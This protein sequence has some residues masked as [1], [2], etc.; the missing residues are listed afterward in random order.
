MKNFSQTDLKPEILPF[1]NLKIGLIA[2][3]TDFTI[4]QD[5]KRICNNQ[6]V[7][8]YVNRIPFNNPLNHENY[9][10]MVDHL[11]E[12][13]KNILPGEKIDSIAYGC[14][15]GTVAI[16]EKIIA[17]KIHQSKPNSYVSTPITAAIKSFSKLKIKKLAVLTPYPKAVNKTIFNFLTKNGIE[18]ISFSSFNLEYDSD[19]AKVNPKHLLRTIND[20]EYQNADAIFVSCTALRAVEILEQAEKDTSKIVIS[21]NQAL[22]WDILTSMKK[23]EE[24]NGYGKLF[25]N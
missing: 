13:A 19:I 25:L 9:L 24:I 16:G 6:K 10:K 14:T 18:I 17:E 3:S 11:P 1:S 4:E 5:F 21:S 20:L 23:T 12:I 2:L 7:D 15:S 8:I 22:V